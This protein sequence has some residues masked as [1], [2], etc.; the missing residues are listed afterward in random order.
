[1]AKKTKKQA[2]VLGPIIV[3]GIITI[4]LMILSF[5]LSL[6]GL[7]SE[8]AVINYS[9]LEMSV[10]SIKNIF[11]IDGLKYLFGSSVTNFRLLE[12]L[13]LIIM[14]LIAISIAEKSGLIKH[15][16]EPFKQ[17]KTSVITFFTLVIC[18]V[19]T[20]FGEYSFVILLPVIGVI[21]KYLGRNPMLGILV[22]FIGITC[23]Y[24]TGIIYN[25][26][27][28]SLGEMT[29]LSA[30]IEVDP[31]F[32]YDVLSCMYIM[33]VSTF[34]VLFL[35]SAIINKYL[36]PKFKRVQVEDDELVL[37]NKALWIT[38]IALMAILVGIIIMILPGGI[39]LDN[40]K[41]TY[42]AKLMSETSPF[43][44]AFMF[45]ILL[46]MM[47][48]GCIY[49]F[50]SGNIKDRLDYNIG[51]CKSFENSGYIFVLMF[52]ASIMY[53]VLE[54]TNIGIVLSA[55]LIN[56]ISS[57]EFSGTLL[58]V[59]FFILVIVMSF[60][61][62][63]THTKWNMASPLIVPLFMRANIAPEF[64]QFIFS[65]ADGVGKTLSPFFIYFIIMLGF[66]QKYNDGDK[67]DITIL[68]TVKLILP[69]VLLLALVWLVVIVSWNII[70]I[71]LGINTYA[72]L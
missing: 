20:F 23:S 25:Y 3:M 22:A 16:T 5:V 12:P 19:M 10:V 6:L 37:S 65:I 60:F 52:F 21:Y 24:G 11:S 27:T 34:I 47:L 17:L 44:N 31:T 48:C 35:G 51:L 43:R 69:T 28:F 9:N 55:I 61:I 49:G 50:I 66:L 63:N 56:F 64:T 8:E 46:T 36:V 18:I 41:T 7:E 1:M 32:S 72:T 29:Q 33:V 57:L 71:P 30:T 14:S 40:S 38:N 42:I 26:N 4:I 62:P 39:L 2:K 54:Y 15:L 68:G 59:F 67:K 53:G 13:A 58:I 70:G 45:I